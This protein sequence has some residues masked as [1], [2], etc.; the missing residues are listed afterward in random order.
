[1]WNIDKFHTKYGVP[2]GSCLGPLL[3]VLYPSKL[4]KIIE[5]HL[6]EVHTYADDTQLYISFNADSR[7]EQSAALSAMQN[8]IVDIRKRILQDRLRLNDDNTE[9]IIIGTRQQLAKVNI[10]SMQV[11]ESSITPT[12]R[13]KNPGCWFD[14]QLKMDTQINSIC[15][16][17]LF[18]LYN[19]R[20]I[21]KFLNF[22][23]TKILVKT[24]RLDFCNS[25]LYGLPNN[26]LHKLQRIQNA[27]ARLICNVGRFEHITPSLYRLHW[28]P[29]NY[30][31]QFKILLFVYKSLNS[32]APPYI[33]ELVELK[34]ASR[35]NPRNS[36]DTLLL[37][38]PS[39]NSLTPKISLVILLTIYHT[40]LM[41]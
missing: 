26:Q 13:V 8:C 18:H 24:S 2:Q 7:A 12:S 16:T 39:F 17:A 35:Y 22:E 30:R 37:S 41:M 21:R 31:I 5:R 23:C 15:K 1:M 36:D 33:S 19:I 38:N 27:A 10:D 32:I 28:L 25:L 14:G 9:F 40:I 34:P 20:R 11:S 3:F 6:P 29:I 4:F